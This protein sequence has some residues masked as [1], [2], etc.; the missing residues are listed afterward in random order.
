MK[1]LKK[2]VMDSVPLTLDQ[3]IYMQKKYPRKLLLL[4][5]GLLYEEIESKKLSEE[6]L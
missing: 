6:K 4:K 1:I 5:K 2:Q 3:Y